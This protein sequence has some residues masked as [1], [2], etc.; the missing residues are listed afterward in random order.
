VDRATVTDE[1]WTVG[2]TFTVLAKTGP[3]EL[4]ED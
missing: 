4:E 3:V 2:D 1:G